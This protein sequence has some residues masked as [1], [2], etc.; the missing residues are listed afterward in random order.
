MSRPIFW[1]QI[2]FLSPVSNATNSASIFSN[3]VGFLP[4]SLC[5]D[6]FGQ[7]YTERKNIAKWPKK[8]YL[9][10]LWYFGVKFPFKSYTWNCLS[11]IKLLPNLNVIKTF[12]NIECSISIWKGR[13]KTDGCSILSLLYPL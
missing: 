8:C 9:C 3:D 2:S 6:S 4:N 7:V 11:F 5:G 13:I 1:I 10:T 12:F